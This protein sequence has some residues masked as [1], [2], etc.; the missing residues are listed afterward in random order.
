MFDILASTLGLLLLSPFFGIVALA[1]KRD[2]PGPVFYRGR[3]AGRH[4]REFYILKFRS[5]YE[6]PESY[7][8]AKV[9]AQDDPRITPVGNPPTGAGWLPTH[10]VLRE[11]L[12]SRCCA[13]GGR[14]SSTSCPNSEFTA[15]GLLGKKVFTTKVTTVHKGKIMK[16]IPS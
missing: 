6:R 4:G 12:P 15:E 2:S 1:I 10:R 13:L 7:Q 9:T 14:P 11:G 16:G 8:G 5:M 3:R